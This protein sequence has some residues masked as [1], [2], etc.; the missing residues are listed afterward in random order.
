MSDLTFDTYLDHLAKGTA[1]FTTDTLKAAL[2]LRSTWTPSKSDAFVATATAA[3]AV[4][5]TASGYARQTLGSKTE[6]VDST[7][8]RVLLSCATIDFGTMAA[9]QS[10]DRL[11]LFKQVT[12][13]TDSWLI[14]ALDVGSLTTD[15]V[16]RRFV[17]NAAGLY[18]I[19]AT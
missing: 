3:G 1:V 8:H 10:Y 7:N 19:V 11:L 16:S 2:V 12:N 18:Q 4:E 15:G 6:S 14:A 13:D 9:A 17:L 5:L